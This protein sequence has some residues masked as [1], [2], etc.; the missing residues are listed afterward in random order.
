MFLTKLK[1]TAAVVLTLGMTGAGAGWAARQSA[2]VA[3][4]QPAAKGKA[5]R[6]AEES[7]AD[8][9]AARDE[10]LKRL[11]NLEDVADAQAEKDMQEIIDARLRVVEVQAQLR[12]VESDVMGA[13]RPEPQTISHLSN[14]INDV[15]TTLARQQEQL[16]PEHPTIKQLSERLA[17]LRDEK[18]IQEKG[19]MDLKEKATHAHP[20]VQRDLVT[21]EERLNFLQQRVAERRNRMAARVAD[22]ADRVRRLE[23]EA[24]PAPD[25]RRMAEIE[26]KLDELL[27]EVRELKR[28]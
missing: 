16:G 5:I 20:G 24:S 25:G 4:E 22:A 3:E 15:K 7:R 11:R 27:R 28:R 21:A 8:A 14:Q 26:R 2:A 6:P 10:A 1:L 23:D 13:G 9:Q 18:A 12:R 17:K 19:L